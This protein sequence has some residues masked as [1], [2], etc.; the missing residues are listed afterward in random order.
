MVPGS[1]SS[2]R[3]PPERERRIGPV[4]SADVAVDA[5]TRAHRDLDRPQTA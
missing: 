5:L 1:C 3:R 4:D 2:S